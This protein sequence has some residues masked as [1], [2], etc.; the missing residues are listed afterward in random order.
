MYEPIY[1]SFDVL[2][3]RSVLVVKAQ[4][5]KNFGESIENLSKYYIYHAR[6]K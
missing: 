4:M 1:D 6:N 3:E 5:K 2:E